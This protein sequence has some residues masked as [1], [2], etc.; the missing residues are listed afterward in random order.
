M[1]TNIESL[2]RDPWRPCPWLCVLVSGFYFLFPS[3]S[4]STVNFAY[5]TY[6]SQ[7]PRPRFP[8]GSKCGLH[9]YAVSFKQI[10]IVALQ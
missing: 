6:F 9:N 5:D 7:L 4:S 2:S 8:W 3:H 1:P 10:L